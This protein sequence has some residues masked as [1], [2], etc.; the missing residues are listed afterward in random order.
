MLSVWIPAGLWTLAGLVVV[1]AL[2][3]LCTILAY[4]QRARRE[5]DEQQPR[6]TQEQSSRL[7]G[8]QE[9]RKMQV[10][11]EAWITDSEETSQEA[12]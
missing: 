9:W 2:A 1:L 11:V 7:A 6:L 3:W 12:E 5:W 4:E 10:E 8:D